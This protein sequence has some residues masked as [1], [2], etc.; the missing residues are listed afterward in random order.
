MEASKTLA[1]KLE[2]M[3]LKAA[4]VGVAL[5]VGLPRNEFQLLPTGGRGPNGALQVVR[6]LETKSGLGSTP[7]LK[8]IIRESNVP[9]IPVPGQLE[10]L[11]LA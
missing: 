1:T 8:L 5:H 6:G 10:H 11:A 7:G 9:L 2:G 3:A 4:S